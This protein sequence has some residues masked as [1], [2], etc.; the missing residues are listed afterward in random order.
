MSLEE[1]FNLSW[2]DFVS[3]SDDYILHS[4]NNSTVP[5]VLQNELVPERY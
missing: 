4:S 5:I 2:E 1:V 3:N